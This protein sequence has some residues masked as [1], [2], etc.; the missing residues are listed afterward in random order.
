MAIK[1][2]YLWRR[3]IR[4]DDVYTALL[5][6]S[7]KVAEPALVRHAEESR[8][9]SESGGV[10][11]NRNIGRVEVY[12]IASSCIRDQVLEV[13]MLDGCGLESR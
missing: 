4:N 5:K 10:I 3:R 7:C 9:I 11:R 13:I 12:E 1:V 6:F 8:R 2:E